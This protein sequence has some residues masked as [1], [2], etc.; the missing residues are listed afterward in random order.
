MK[1]DAVQLA[2]FDEAEKRTCRRQ[3]SVINIP[4]YRRHTTARETHNL[5]L[6]L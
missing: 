1:L 6:H 2:H 3:V 4:D 5:Y